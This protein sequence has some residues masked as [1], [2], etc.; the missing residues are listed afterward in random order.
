[1]PSALRTR[2]FYSRQTKTP[3]KKNDI[4]S[5]TQ[6]REQTFSKWGPDHADLILSGILVASVLARGLMP[7]S[8]CT[9]AS[10]PLARPRNNSSDLVR[11]HIGLLISEH[12]NKVRMLRAGR[13][14]GKGPC[15]LQLKRCRSS[16]HLGADKE[17]F[18]TL[19]RRAG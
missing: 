3:H 7:K 2:N 15:L 16:V 11:T 12:Q 14:T 6:V 1:M 9:A 4:S 5:E 10:L 17:V 18:C 8:T 19:T 13:T